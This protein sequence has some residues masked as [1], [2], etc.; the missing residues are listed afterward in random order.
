[1]KVQQIANFLESWAPK[2]IQWERDNTGLLVGSNR[3]KVTGVLLCLDVTD[4]ALI[5]AQKLKCNLIISHHPLIFLPLKKINPD[6]DRTSNLIYS[7]IK[8]DFSL[9]SY[10]TNL[11]FTRDGVNFQTAHQL[12]LQNIEFLKPISG[13]SLKI[14]AFVPTNA[15]ESLSSAI[16]DAGGGVVGEYSHCGYTSTGKGSF[17]G[18]DKSN[19]TIGKVGNLEEVEEIRLEVLVNEGNLNK[20]IQAL[21]TAHPYEEPAFDIY[22][23]RNNETN[24]GF[25]VI[26]TLPEAIDELN[27][28]ELTAKQL[29]SPFLR[30]S[31]L[32]GKKILKVAIFGGSASEHLPDAI[33]AGCDAFITSDISYH[34]FQD[35]EK[36]ILMID[37]GHYETEVPVLSEVK[38]R[39]DRYFA[40]SGE[41][42]KVFIYNEDANPVKYYCL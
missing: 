20:V 10:H 33:E 12:G 15:V 38:S 1:M 26:G 2:Y 24:A 34:S 17:L 11:D 27:F 25:G 23:L 41:Q 29:G 31:T 40:Q 22:P 4:D 35:A 7:L 39:L 42:N 3:Q 37:A 14:V 8:N 28:L 21:K 19:P 32:E 6:S 36:K 30:H 13:K 18:S 9:L 5:R 16:F